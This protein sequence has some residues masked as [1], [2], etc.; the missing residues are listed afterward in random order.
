[1]FAAKATLSETTL[2]ANLLPHSLPSAGSGHLMPCRSLCD[3]VFAL[4]VL[5]DRKLSSILPSYICR[6]IP[7][8]LCDSRGVGKHMQ[9]EDPVCQPSVGRTNVNLDLL[10]APK[11]AGLTDEN[12]CDFV[13]SPLL[14]YFC[15]LG[16]IC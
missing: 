4:F 13:L 8:L 14:L 11:K 6:P 15:C 12:G 1:M 2:S 3:A 5:S 9:R 16:G 10:L 7:D